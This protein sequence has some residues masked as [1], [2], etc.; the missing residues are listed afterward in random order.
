MT[1]SG[2]DFIANEIDKTKKEKEK[3]VVQRYGAAYSNNQ[4][5]VKNVK[6]THTPCVGFRTVDE[7]L[8]DFGAH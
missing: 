5:S 4:Y 3:R 1:D 8:R 7:Y 2:E 6:N